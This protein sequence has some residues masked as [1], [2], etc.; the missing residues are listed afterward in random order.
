MKQTTDEEWKDPAYQAEQLGNLLWASVSE[1]GEFAQSSIGLPLIRAMDDVGLQLVMCM[2]RKTV[3]EHLQCIEEVRRGLTPVSYWL[4]RAIKRGLI[5]QDKA[6]GLQARL[7]E[8]VRH[9]DE[10]CKAVVRDANEQIAAQR[11]GQQT[12]EAEAEEAAAA[13]H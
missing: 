5:L 2:G 13:A 6:E 3:K 8:L 10:Q 9:L 1:W 4:Q 12:E 7:V 11:Q